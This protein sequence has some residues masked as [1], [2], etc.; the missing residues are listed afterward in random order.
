MRYA[1]SIAD[2]NPELLQG[3]RRRGGLLPALRA[4]L[5]FLRTLWAVRP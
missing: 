4:V 3:R 1:R 5:E 2:L